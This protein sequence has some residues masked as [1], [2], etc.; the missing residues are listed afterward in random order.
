MNFKKYAFFFI[1]LISTKVSAIDYNNYAAKS[2]AMGN[3]GVANKDINASFTNQAGLAFITKA[4]IGIG[5]QQKFMLNDIHQITT[6]FALPTKTGTFSANAI[7][8]GFNEFNETKIGLGFGKKL[9]EKTSM[10]IQVDY[11]QQH[12]TNEAN[13]TAFTFQLGLLTQV[14]KKVSLGFHTFNP[15]PLKRNIFQTQL[16]SNFSMGM[17]WKASKMVV[18]NTEI[19]SSLTSLQPN[20]KAGVEYNLVKKFYLRGGFQT[21]PTLYCFGFGYYFNTFKID[22]SNSV[23]AVLGHTTQFNLTYLF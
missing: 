12:I 5:F 10:G 23:H 18:V 16:P 2:A 4:Q 17:Q 9:S 14:S 7:Y 1:V 22:F 21:Q 8:F 11:L 13:Q 15:Y 19:A 6:A 20:F 3:T